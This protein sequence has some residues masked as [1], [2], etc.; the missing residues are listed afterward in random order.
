VARDLLT[1][2]PGG[3]VQGQVRYGRVVIESGG[4]I[5]GDM[6]ALSEDEAMGLRANHAQDIEPAA[7]ETAPDE[8]AAWPADNGGEPPVAPERPDDD[9]SKR[10]L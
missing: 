4:E 1:V 3:R 10:P 7:E 5:S 8:T 9:P 6:R 2:R